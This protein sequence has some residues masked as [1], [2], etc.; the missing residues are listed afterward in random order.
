MNTPQSLLL[1]VV[2][3]MLP[4]CVLIGMAQRF[5]KQNV[6]PLASFDPRHWV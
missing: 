5:R 2:T 3:L 1:G 6:P 4:G